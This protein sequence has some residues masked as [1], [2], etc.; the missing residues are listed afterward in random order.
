MKQSAP[1]DEQ[2]A[3]EIIGKLRT[4]KD[5]GT[6]R[7]FDVDVQVN[8]SVVW[9][10]GRVA[11]EAQQSLVL[12]ISRRVRGVKQVVNDLHVSSPAPVQVVSAPVSQP[13]PCSPP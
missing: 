5:R 3:E 7:N 1:S 6:L 10:S 11:S 9:V 2:L 4:Q 12:D 13:A 8:Q